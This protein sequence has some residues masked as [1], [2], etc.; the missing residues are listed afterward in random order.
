[1]SEP[2]TMKSAAK[3]NFEEIE[4]LFSEG[5]ER[6]KNVIKKY[7]D[8]ND[9]DV[10]K[11]TLYVLSSQSIHKHVPVFPILYINASKGSGKSRLLKLMTYLCG[12]R[13]VVQPTETVLFRTT[14]PLFI[15]EFE[16]VNSKDKQNI[17]ELLNSAYKNGATVP[18][19]NKVEYIEKETGKKIHNYEVREYPIYKPIVI[20]NIWGM[21]EVLGDRCLPIT[22]EHSNSSKTKMIENFENDGECQA[23]KFAL[24]KLKKRVDS[25]LSVDSVIRIVKN[26]VDS[27]ISDDNEASAGSG[28]SYFQKIYILWND[29][30]SNNIYTTTL[31]TSTTLTTFITLKDFFDCLRESNISGRELELSFPFFLVAAF[32]SRPILENSIKLFK[33]YSFQKFQDEIL[34]S[35]DTMLI[36]FISKIEDEEKENFVSLV[37]LINHFKTFRGE[38]DSKEDWLNSRWMTRALK[39]IR[40]IKLKR[41]LANGI[42]VIVNVDKAKEKLKLF[43]NEVVAKDEME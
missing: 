25:V 14:E 10:E 24:S 27:V 17:R 35:Y 21:G 8:M 23:C 19:A 11:V 32:V 9:E 3:S 33:D 13:Y 36:D 38:E 12:G 18:R 5:Y 6:T 20:A 31:T 29:Y 37:K 41:R 2:I 34:E 42:E 26:S 4:E 28:E 7:M 16:Q 30:I 22:L 39:R 15:D 1:M 40:L 43:S